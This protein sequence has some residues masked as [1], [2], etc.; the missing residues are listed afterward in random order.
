MAN[1]A[2]TSRRTVLTAGAA[3]AAA[4]AAGGPA[5][6]QAEPQNI[7]PRPRL[8][9]WRLVLAARGRPARKARPQGVRAD[10]HRPRRTR[11]S[12]QR[13]G[14]SQHP[15]HRC[16]EPDQVRGPAEYRAG[17]T[18]LCRGDHHGRRRT[19]AAF[20]R[21]DRVHRRVP[22]GE[23]RHHADDDHR[24]LC[25]L[26][27]WRPRRR[28]TSRAR[29]SRRRR[30]VSTKRTAPGSIPSSRPNR[31]GRHSRRSS[32]PGR[33]TRWRRKPTSARSAIRSRRSTSGWRSA[34]PTRHGAPTALK[35]PGTTSWWINPTC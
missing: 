30:S 5:Q 11:P 9:A 35:T 17:R 26:R 28:A 16:R 20:D 15:C 4:A 24:E 23:R 10:A 7:R 22:A 8:V 34:R 14:R 31:S 13:L 3:L 32:S 1:D 12:A 25:G 18:L 29:S 6:A 2:S 33:A 19:G 27:R 21:F